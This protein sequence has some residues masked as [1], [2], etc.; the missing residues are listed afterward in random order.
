MAA[1]FLNETAKYLHK[2]VINFEIIFLDITRV[3]CLLRYFKSYHL[4][5]I[6]SSLL[7]AA[8]WSYFLLEIMMGISKIGSN[9]FIKT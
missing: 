3:S 1:M 8:L 9:A 6:I 7:I 5:F 2:L 4:Q